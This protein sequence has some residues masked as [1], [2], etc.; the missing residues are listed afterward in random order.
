MYNGG[1]PVKVNTPRM[2]TAGLLLVY[3]KY[4]QVLC[5]IFCRGSPGSPSGCYLKYAQKF[6]VGCLKNTQNCER[7]HAWVWVPPGD[8]N[9]PQD[10]IFLLIADK[11]MFY[12]VLDH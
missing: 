1:T 12:N 5:G 10:D 6:L 3:L 4:A 8:P 9:I 11:S 7:L 2:L